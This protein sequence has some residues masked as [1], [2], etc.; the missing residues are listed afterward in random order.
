MR[1]SRCQHE[2]ETGAKFCEECGAPLARVCAQCGRQLSPTAKFCPECAHPTGRSDVPPTAPRFGSPDSYTPRY[3]AERILTSKAAIEGERKRV[4]VLFSDL[5]GSM[6]IVAERD[7]EAARRLLDPVLEQMMEAVH[8]FDGTVNQVMGDGIMALFG[9]PLAYEDH[10]VRACYA[11]LRMQESVKRYA[12]RVRREHGVTLRIRVG[13]N[14]GEVVVRAIGNDLHMD[15]T[16]VGQTTHLAARMEQLAD[17]GTVLI[18]PETLALVEG[19]VHVKPLGPIAVKGLAEPVPVFELIGAAAHTRLEAARSR[20]FTP[21]VGRDAEMEQLRQAADL[22]GR[23]RGQIVA[24]VGEA[25]VGKSRLFYEFIHSHRTTGWLVLESR[26][27][28]YGKATPFLPLVDLL[29]RYLR[30]EDRGDARTVRAS[31]TG[32][33]LTLDRA[34]DDVVPAVM[35]LFD[36]LE[37][38]DDYLKMDAAQRRRRAIDGVKRLLL[39]ESQVQPLLLVFEDL[40]WIDAETQDLL[41]R[42]VDG[43]PTAPVL[44]AVNYRPE[45]R[46]GWGGKTYYQQLRIDP[47]PPQ[48]AD[49]LLATLV[50]THP[51]VRPLIRLL[52]ERTEGNP[53]FLEE[54]VRALVETRALVGDPGAYRL[55]NPVTA[56]EVPGTVQAILAARI[57]RLPP[58]LKRLLQAA[59]VVG[60]DVPVAVLEAIADTS[61]S[62]VRQGLTELQTAEFLY[63]MRLFPELEYTFK[64]ALTHEVAY[65]SVLHDR[66]RTLHAAIV[67]AIERLHGDRLAER[68]ELLA[69]HAAR[70]GVTAKAMHYLCEAGK[71]ALARSA[72][73]EALGFFESALGVLSEL[74]QSPATLSDGL[75]IRI[76][77]GPALIALKGGSSPEVET[78]YETALETVGALDDSS[79]RFPVIWG[80][81]YVSYTRGQYP[82]AREAGTRLLGDAEA[83]GDSGRVL[84]AYHA[85][86]ATLLA[87]GDPLGA[88]P[89]MERG[90]ALYDPERHASQTFLYGGHNPGACCRY[91]LALGRWLLGYPDRAALAARDVLRFVDELKHPLT[92]MLASWFVACLQYLSGERTAL[93][94]TVERL[95]ALGA[96]HG[97]DTWMDSALVLTPILRGER[98]G[99]DVL[100]GMH[101]RLRE[102]QAAMWRR[103][104]GFCVLA[105]LY[106][107]AGYPDEGRRVLSDISDAHRHA[108][109]G[110]EVYRL[111][112]ELLL[113]GASPATGEAERLLVTAM[114]LARTRGEKSLELRAAMSLARLW[115]SSRQ[116]EAARRTL[117][118]VYDWFTEGADTHDLQEA[119]RLLAQLAR[120]GD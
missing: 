38:D 114:E 89:H 112:A 34:L 6:E 48:S 83:G 7:P 91:Q 119:R 71:K 53:F 96:E 102:T 116:R 109:L 50:G 30:I 82:A 1:C 37:P 45:Y 14:S 3:L 16:A 69:H 79:R 32:G 41:D 29:R 103:V 81:W 56:V 26:S 85:L 31:I 57:D 49:E 64:H 75:N 13:L 46:H 117:A 93:G 60:K 88:L 33:L 62:D 118:S 107:E 47:L 92:T 39:R 43:L 22:A 120:F 110:P 104:F 21:F 55:M 52:I 25:G 40:H 28:S 73:R 84:E 108:F 77:M 97:F 111:E 65:G 78:L 95:I 15:Y 23:A 74:P 54:S 20:G 80:L 67:G 36:A 2:N 17:P 99:R 12:E 5:R 4:T 87:A 72:N 70:G 61:A 8:R 18:T 27:V 66:R 86:W 10:A 35:W 90:I 106:A 24:V 9:A 115:Q 76:A 68:V 51:S 98:P 59:S 100:A 113:R 94:H 58:E 19:F 105:E 44:L 42:M 11:A 63:E 101:R